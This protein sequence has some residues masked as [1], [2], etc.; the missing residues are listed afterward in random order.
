MVH[1]P[2]IEMH[3]VNSFESGGTTSEF[4]NIDEA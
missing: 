3:G 2:Q 1:F 4:V